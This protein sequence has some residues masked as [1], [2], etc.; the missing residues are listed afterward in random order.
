[1]HDNRRVRNKARTTESLQVATWLFT[2]A[3]SVPR[4]ENV[5]GSN[6]ERK[7][8]LMRR[9]ETRDCQRVKAHLGVS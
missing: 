2:R 6:L 1:M 7:Q 5:G 8:F 9:G 4:G 3:S